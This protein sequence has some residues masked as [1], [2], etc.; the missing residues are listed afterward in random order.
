MGFSKSLLA[1]P[2]FWLAIIY[3]SLLV[4]SGVYRFRLPAAEVPAD[5]KIALVPAF[6]GKIN[7]SN[8]IR[9]TYKEK[10]PHK[11]TDALPVILVHGSPGS[12]GAFDGLTKHITDRRV[13]AVDLPGFG[14]SELDIPDY[15]ILSHSQY[16][17]EIM[18]ALQIE[19]AHF[20]GF[21][22]GGGVILHLADQSPERVKSVSMIS[23]IGVQEYE[24]FGN[25]YSNHIAHAVQV[26]FVWTLK[27][28]TPHFGIF[29]GMILTYARNFYD[30]DQRPLRG[31]LDKIET[32]FQIIHGKEDPL[33]PVEA[34]RE[35]ARI[36]PQSEYHELDDN[37][38]F[39]FIRPEKIKELLNG[40]WT[41][42][43]NGRAISRSDAALERISEARKPFIGKI[44]PAI[45]PTAFVFFLF[46]AFLAIF[47]EDFAFVTG[48]FFAAQGRFGIAFVI[49]ACVV[50]SW[51]C[52][53]LASL[54]G[55]RFGK[56]AVA[57]IGSSLRG[58][59]LARRLLSFRLAD[60]FNAG[61]RREGYWKSL[62][63]FMVVSSVWAIAVIGISYF[64]TLG[65][66]GISLIDIENTTMSL[67][68][69]GI[70]I[71]VIP[72]YRT[73]KN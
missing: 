39:I 26:G 53:F 51:L 17:L 73:Y 5:K 72:T 68:L 71:V 55:R 10:A 66:A 28:L 62:I 33:V 23:S 2:L 69:I 11:T 13:I 41:R 60:Y 25:Y 54:I 58:S 14:D 1:R 27:E 67:V 34:A 64:V 37:H 35:H 36:V 57:E 8:T 16:L 18:N 22:L 47:I 50:G 3:L 31:I 48:G 56:V 29:D 59:I 52:I 19:K 32:P 45:G 21:S 9:I 4:W 65:M 70:L 24:L 44:L 6:D 49:I 40:F 46:L 20:V 7:L 15:S 38:F 30:T 61:R 12:A 42:A 43:E 63:K